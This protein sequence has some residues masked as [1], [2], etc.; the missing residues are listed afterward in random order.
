[1]VKEKETGL[2]KQTII[3]HGV[4]IMRT[5]IQKN[6]IINYWEEINKYN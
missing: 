1:M 2:K 5:N 3:I 6:P 4:T